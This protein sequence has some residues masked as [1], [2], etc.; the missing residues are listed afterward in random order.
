[1]SNRPATPS[2]SPAATFP[3][4]SKRRSKSCASVWSIILFS[5]ILSAGCADSPPRDEVAAPEPTHTVAPAS[6]ATAAAAT[7]APA[8]ATPAVPAE[9]APPVLVEENSVFFRIRSALISAEDQEKLKRHA[10]R[11]KADRRATVTLVGHTDELGSRSY[12]LALTEERLS[13][14][15]KKLRSYGVAPRQIRRNRSGGVRQ[16]AGCTTDK[17][18]DRARRVELVYSP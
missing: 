9:V 14:V 6:A 18:R 4:L 15:S 8:D 7:S 3:A 5:A 2:P 16:H 1:M 17:C 11:L 12:N 10:G 13:A